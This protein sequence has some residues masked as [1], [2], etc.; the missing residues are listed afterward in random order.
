MPS[1]DQSDADDRRQHV[2]HAAAGNARGRQPPAHRQGAD[3]S[4]RE[5]APVG[6]H[7][8]LRHHQP[9]EHVVAH[10]GQHAVAQGGQGV[11]GDGVGAP[12]QVSQQAAEHAEHRARGAGADHV[13][14]PID[15]GQ[16]AG[17]SREQVEHQEADVAQQPLDELAGPRGRTC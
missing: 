4:A 9:E 14:V 11:A 2:D 5:A 15:A 8:D 10:E 1:V 12:H 16:A 7:V 3:E 6:H 13:G 17:Q